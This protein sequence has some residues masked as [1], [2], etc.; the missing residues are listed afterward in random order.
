M[1]VNEKYDCLYVFVCGDL[2]SRTANR[3]N[4]CN[5]DVTDENSDSE[6]EGGG[7]KSKDKTVNTFGAELLDMCY[8]HKMRILNGNCDGDREGEFTFVSH[9]GSSGSSVNDYFLVSLDFPESKIVQVHVSRRV[10]SQHMPMSL[11]LNTACQHGARAT[12]DQATVLTKLTKLVWQE[13]QPHTNIPKQCQ[14]KCVYKY[15]GRGD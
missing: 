15:S 5:N 2:N 6:S 11:T 3:N 10:E 13:R 1:Y 7:R 9:S 8:I 14:V 12:A 4:Y